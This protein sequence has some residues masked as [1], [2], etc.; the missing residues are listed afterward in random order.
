MH[1]ISICFVLLSCLF[2]YQ[3]LFRSFVPLQ[4]IPLFPC[5]ALFH[6]RCGSLITPFPYHPSI[7][8]SFIILLISLLLRN[9]VFVPTVCSSIHSF[10]PIISPSSVLSHFPLSFRSIYFLR[11]TPF[12]SFVPFHFISSSSTIP[13]FPLSTPVILVV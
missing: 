10:L 2:S 11:H 12:P 1:L 9:K 4:F 13:P 8:S 3:S 5:S 7:S 6:P